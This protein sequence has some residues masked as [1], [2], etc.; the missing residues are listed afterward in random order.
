M[1]RVLLRN[2]ENTLGS[3]RWPRHLV[4]QPKPHE[5]AGCCKRTSG[6]RFG[7]CFLL[8]GGGV[9]ILSKV[10]CFKVLGFRV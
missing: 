3:E 4:A 7:C 6:R 2:L 1:E 9:E 8:G 5:A 10:S